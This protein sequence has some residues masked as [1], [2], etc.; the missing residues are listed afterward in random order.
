MYAVAIANGH[1]NRRRSVSFQAP[2]GGLYRDS[3]GLLFSMYSKLSEEEDDKMV[4]GWQK[5]A[6]GILIFV[7]PNVGILLLLRA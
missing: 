6:E 4:E 7:S 2:R 1:V 5:E 3:S